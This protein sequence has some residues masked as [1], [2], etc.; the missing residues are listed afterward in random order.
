MKTQFIKTA[1]VSCA[2]LAVSSPYAIAAGGN[3]GKGAQGGKQANQITQ[4]VSNI[5]QLEATSLKFMRE[6][7]KLARDVY[8]SLYEVWGTPIF[9]NISDSEQQHTDTVA[10]LLAKYGIDDPV[11]DNTVGVYT[12]PAFTELFHALVNY[13]SESFENALKVGT[14]IEELDIADLNE[15]LHVINKDDIIDAYNNLLKGSRNHLR[16]FYSLV[17]DAGFE[18]TPSHITQEEFDAIV[19]SDYE[20]GN[21][22]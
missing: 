9:K 18:Y 13:G 8:I 2:I 1:L 21:I 4:S 15:Q 5:S 14:E 3:G 20:T 22:N 7:E 17:L 11:K 19:N 12:D 6:E 10:K 16:S